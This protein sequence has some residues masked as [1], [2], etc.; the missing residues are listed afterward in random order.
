MN[1]VDLPNGRR[2]AVLF[3]DTHIGKWV[4]ENGRLDHDQ[5]MLPLLIP[6][7]GHGAVVDVGAFIGDHT[8]FYAKHASYVVAFEPNREAFDCLKFNMRSHS[9]VTC[10]PVGL[11]ARTGGA[12]I[13]KNDNAGM[14]VLVDGTDIDVLT[15]DSFGLSGVTFIK[16]DAE[17]WECD[18]LEGARDTIGRCRPSMLIEVNDAALRGQGRTPGELITKIEGMQYRLRNIYEGQ[19]M[20]GPQYDVLCT[21]L[22]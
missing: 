22:F 5:N 20:N 19:P 18:V 15:L 13:I 10:H 12:S 6:H 1:V 17:G 14:A 3:S 11:G 9:N 8:E 4:V 2:V 16:I 7:L 21:P